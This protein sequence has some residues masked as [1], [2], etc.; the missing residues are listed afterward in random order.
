LS[1]ALKFVSDSGFI[2]VSSAKAGKFIQV[3]VA[4]TGE[5]ISDSDKAILFQKF[6]QAHSHNHT[7]E[8]GTGLGLYISKG[9]VEAH[10][11]RIW[12]EDNK[13]VGCKFIFTLP[14]V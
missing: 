7:K 9:I 12:I 3:T 2:T 6:V 11:G 8:R 5:G 10:S 14:L 1:N 13:P 4:D